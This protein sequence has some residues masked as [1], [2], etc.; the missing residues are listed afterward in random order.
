[1]EMKSRIAENRTKHP[2][3][4]AQKPMKASQVII[5]VS[6]SSQVGEVRRRAGQL[7]GDAG[8]G[9]TQCGNAAIVATELATNL[10]R[11]ATGGEMILTGVHSNGSG[12]AWVELLSVDRGPGIENVGLSL[13]DGFSTGHGMGNGLGA[14]RRLSTEWDL[15]SMPASTSAPGGSVVLARISQ[16]GLSPSSRWSVWGAISRPAPHE[17]SCGDTWRV[18]E[19][20]GEF[21][22]MI[23]DGLGHGPEA[24]HAADEAGDVFDSDPFADL[25]AMLQNADVRMQRTRGAAVAA[26]R[27]DGPG[28]MVRFIGVGNI[29]ASLR[30]T[31]DNVRLGLVSHNGI[32]GGRNCKIQEFQHACFPNSFLVMH[33]DGLQSRWS[34]K[35]YLGLLARHPA[36]IAAILYRDF[37]RGRDDVTVAVVRLN[38]E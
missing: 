32:V 30:S 7:A 33:S 9:E 20:N 15:Y 28:R 24:A 31:D 8:L 16:R 5:P 3:A 36:I 34:L 12:E 13:Q 17:I 35:P 14:V 38:L 29:A 6:D 21:A 23:A 11:Y 1:L 4:E 10:V 18:A 26:A 19:R 37:T 22:L 2:A 25:S 27:I